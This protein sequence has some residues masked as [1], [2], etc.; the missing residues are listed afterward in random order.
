M[1]KKLPIIRKKTVILTNQKFKVKAQI[2]SNTVTS[3]ITFL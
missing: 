3:L 1:K 2:T